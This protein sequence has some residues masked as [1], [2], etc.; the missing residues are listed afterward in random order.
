MNHLLYECKDPQ[1][2]V[3]RLALFK[4][5][6]LLAM[7]ADITADCAE[8]LKYWLNLLPDQ[9][10]APLPTVDCTASPYR[11]PYRVTL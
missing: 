5:L 8:V 3:I 6:D 9:C 11:V 10:H 4:A 1:V 7:E 2:L